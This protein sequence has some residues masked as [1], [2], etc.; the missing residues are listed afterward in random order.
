MACSHVFV[1]PAL[2]AAMNAAFC[3][4]HTAASYSIGCLA[5]GAMLARHAKTP[6]AISWRAFSVVT[7]LCAAW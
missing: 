2:C 4:Y 5:E 1:R 6:Q 3:F 7:A